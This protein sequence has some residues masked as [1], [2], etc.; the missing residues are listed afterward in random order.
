VAIENVVNSDNQDIKTMV[1]LGRYFSIFAPRQSG[2][3][4]FLEEFLCRHNIVFP[5]LQKF[6]YNPVLF[7]DGDGTL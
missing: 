7:I 2:K 3:T 5:G 6:R 1:D 4:T